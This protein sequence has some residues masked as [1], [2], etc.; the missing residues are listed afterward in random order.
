MWSVGDIAGEVGVSPL[1]ATAI[2]SET[3]TLGLPTLCLAETGTL[4]ALC[5]SP[6]MCTSTRQQLFV[7]NYMT[8]SGSI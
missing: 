6:V 1:T 8:M 2:Q 3:A 4:A 7:Y 5:P